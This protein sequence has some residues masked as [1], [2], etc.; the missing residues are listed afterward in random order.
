MHSGIFYNKHFLSCIEYGEG[1]IILRIKYFPGGNTSKGFINLFEFITPPWDKSDFKYILKGGPG[2]G[3]NTLMKKA[4]AFASSA[5][6]TVEEFR[7]ASD[8]DSLDAVRIIEK[9]VVI[10]DGTAPHIIDPKLPG[11]NDIIVDIGFFKDK[12]LLKS[13]EERLKRLQRENKIH[14]DFAYSYLSSAFNIK[15]ALVKSIENLVDK[16]LIYDTLLNVLINVNETGKETR[17]LFS[18]TYTPEGLIDVE[19]KLT[20][21]YKTYIF[22]GLS[23]YFVM[24]AALSLLENVRKTVFYDP[25]FTDTA[26]LILIKDTKIALS[27]DINGKENPEFADVQSKKELKEIFDLSEQLEKKAINELSK[28]KSLHDEIEKLYK[29]HV[30]FEKVTK[31]SEE[32]IFE[33]GF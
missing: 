5:G 7:C 19:E 14:Y 21:E 2:V 11:A 30:D 12:E 18:K 9:G 32:L 23:G 24:K 1:V 6:Y 10:L 22:S 4:A 15:S 25:L 31:R 28:A 29:V 3:K 13:K 27:W 26:N 8:P 33:I 17:Y 16:E 20:K